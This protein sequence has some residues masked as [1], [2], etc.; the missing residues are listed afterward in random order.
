MIETT[1]FEL[2]LLTV[3]GRV[4]RPRPA[5]EQ[6]V[7]TALAFIGPRPARVVD[8][9]TG[10][11][12]LAVTIAGAAPAARVW[13]TDTSLDAVRVARANVERHGL[14]K[15]VAVRH[16]SLLDPVPGEIDLVVANLPYLPLAE[17]PFRP[18]L[19]GEPREAVF[20][21]GDGL[22]PYR[23]LIEACATRLGPDGAVAIQ[24]HRRVLAARG[25]ELCR[26]RNEI[27][28]AST[29]FAEAA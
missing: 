12:A 19:A 15:R 13:A 18:D 3:P 14:A 28:A 16:G 5:S 17:A 25:D 7:A 29:A 11:G 6:L 2:P 9:G 22:D 23:R 24:L 21:P 27:E 20:A 8:V 10:S 4:M 26:L 1:F